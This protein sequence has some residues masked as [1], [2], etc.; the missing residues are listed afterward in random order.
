MKKQQNVIFLEI[1]FKINILLTKII[2][3]LEIIA[4]IQVNKEVLHIAH[5]IQ[6]IVYLKKLTFF[7]MDK[8]VIII[9]S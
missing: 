3:T 9:L 8:T 2:V 7:T 5:V 1:R 6:N 4:I